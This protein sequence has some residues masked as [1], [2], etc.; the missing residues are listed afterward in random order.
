VSP[1]EVGRAAVSNAQAAGGDTAG[2]IHPGKG[3][4]SGEERTYAAYVNGSS[5]RR[6]GPRMGRSYFSG[7]EA[8]IPGYARGGPAPIVISHSHGPGSPRGFDK[9]DIPSADGGSVL[10]VR[11]N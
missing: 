4:N 10:G 2:D 11:Y 9:F 5:L 7:R 6:S 3:F 1:E 8:D